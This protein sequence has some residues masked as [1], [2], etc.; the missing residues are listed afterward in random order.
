MSV[1]V[2]KRLG[3]ICTLINGAAFKSSDFIDEGVPVLK[4]AN[5]KPNKILL[6]DLK[7]VSQ[8]TAEKKA[9]A[10]IHYGDIL[11]TMTGNRKDGG[12]ESW[13]GKAALFREHGHYMLNQRLCIIRPNEDEV[14]TQ[15]LAYYLSSWD[16][17]LYF[18]NRATSSGGQANI[19]PTIV[20]DYEIMMPDLAQQRRIAEL[21]NL[22]DI[23]IL[24]NEKINRNLTLAA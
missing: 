13:V 14:D 9:K 19:S 12:P 22:L 2:K 20:N 10:R 3:D 6:N 1:W 16:S 15:Y 5:V 18:I 24:N 11:L 4:I 23:K 7:C 17:Q 8:E 21:L